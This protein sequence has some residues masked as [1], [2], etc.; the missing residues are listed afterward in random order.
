MGD[1]ERQRRESERSEIQ[2]QLAMERLEKFK[3]T[4]LGSKIVK[5]GMG[6]YERQTGERLYKLKMTELGSKDQD[7]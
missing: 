7:C 2:R 6:D 1:Y 5:V 4:E 3:K